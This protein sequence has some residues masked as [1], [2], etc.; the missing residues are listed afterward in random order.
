VKE[1]ETWPSQE[2][3]AFVTP[4]A[5]MLELFRKL[6]GRFR[7]DLVGNTRR[8]RL[9]RAAGALTAMK[10][11]GGVITFVAGLLYARV[12]GPHGYGV[13]S[14]VIAW[15]ALLAVPVALGL[16]QL[17]VRQ[18]A[19]FPHTIA[20]LR[21]WSDVRVSASGMLAAI[22]MTVAAGL[23]ALGGGTGWPFLAAAPLPLL[24]GVASVRSALLQSVGHVARSQWPR[25]LLAPAVGLSL[26]IALWYLNG[27]FTPTELVV[28]SM[29]GATAALV[30]ND[31]RLRRLCPPDDGSRLAPIAIRHALPF[32]WITGLY[33]LNS[34]MDILML[35]TIRG[36]HDA[37][38]YV[39]SSRIAELTSLFMAAANMVL[40]PRIAQLHQS[41]E[42][43]LLQ[44]MIRGAGRS[45]LV[46]SAPVGITLIL[47]S[48]PLLSFLYGDAYAEGAQVLQILATSQLL[49]VGSG[50]LGIL[51][52]MTG[53]QRALSTNMMVSVGLNA[54]LNLALIPA[55]G[56]VGAALAT[57]AALVVSRI[58]LWRQVRMLLAIRPTVLRR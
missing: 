22:G 46:L 1:S 6:V 39:V 2:S 45:V 57:S 21:R 41:G 49:I 47:F 16:P 26:A 42:M 31:W 58:L 44:R 4:L 36:G 50:P 7:E 18:G 23:V 28:A 12:L 10:I 30:V 33:L 25:L 43:V 27:G 32:M 40:A 35:G 38:I 19:R 3:P 8:G 34:R 9:V 5:E 17:L 29:I 52:S 11:G 15:A 14:Y 13:Y 51:L 48:D 37:G 20:K 56:G 24:M 53:H 54:I 55:L